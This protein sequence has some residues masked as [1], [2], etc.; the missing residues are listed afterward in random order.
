MTPPVSPPEALIDDRQ[1]LLPEPVHCLVTTRAIVVTGRIPLDKLAP[2][3]GQPAC[4][5]ALEG[6]LEMVLPQFLHRQVDQ[7]IWSAP[8][9]RT[10][11]AASIGKY[12]PVPHG[13]SS[14]VLP[15]G[16]RRSTR[17]THP[18]CVPEGYSSSLQVAASAS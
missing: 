2:H 12:L 8:A 15:G 6:L 14:T 3:R 9:T 11:A 4:R 16:I 7:A 1:T 17:A 13:A 5:K 10:P 18:R